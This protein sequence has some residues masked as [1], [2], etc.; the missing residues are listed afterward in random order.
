MTEMMRETGRTRAV[1]RQESQ[2][3]QRFR[4]NFNVLQVKKKKKKTPGQQVRN[5]GANALERRK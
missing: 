5:A 2:V 4:D 1:T 3:P